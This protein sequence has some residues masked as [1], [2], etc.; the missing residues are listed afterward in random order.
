MKKVFGVFVLTVLLLVTACGTNNGD[1]KEKVEY[2]N[3]PINFIVPW[4]AG[5]TSDGQVRALAEIAQSE[6]YFGVACNV[7]NRDGAGGTIATT[8]FK[9]ADP[10]GYN[11]CLEA[12]GVFT[13]QPFARSVKYAI[14][15]FKP[16]IGTTLEPIVMV[17]SKQSGYKSIEDMKNSS[18]TISYGFS[19]SGS[20]IQLAQKKFFDD[21]KIN[22]EG[23]PFDGSAP[24]I[25]ALLGGHIDI[26]A[27]HP[28]DLQQYIESGD[29][30]PIGVFGE[31]RDPR[32]AFS[33]IKTFKEQGYDI[34]M[35]VWKF[36]VVPKDTPDEVVEKIHDTLA[37]VMK[38]EKFVD[39]CEANSLLI[40]SYS[41]KEILEKIEAE[42]AVNKTLMESIK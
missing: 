33:E 16:V 42:A 32:E 17:A 34:D 24:T 1:Q 40:T 9:T 3:K 2:P 41:N 18:K 5:G 37:Q 36:L 20:L 22:A 12:V 13:T 10:D 29:L 30:I 38:D 14:E 6:K 7:V 39:Y 26:G 31:E 21:S 8:E 28:G 15:D 27:A 35:S 4:S 23:V 25:T 11:I 19:G